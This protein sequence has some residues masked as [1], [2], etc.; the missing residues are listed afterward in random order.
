MS[1]WRYIASRLH[2]DGTENVIHADL[3]LDKVQ[4]TDTLSGPQAIN[5]SIKPEV[6]SLIGSDGEPVFDAWSTAIYAEKDGQIRGGSILDDMTAKG[7]GTLQLNTIGFAGYPKGMPYMGDYQGIQVDPIDV[8]RHIWDHLQ[9]QPHGNLGVT[10]DSTKSGLKIG[11]PPEQVQ[12]TTGAGEDVSFVAGPVKL[13]WYQTHDLLNKINELV[14]ETPFDYREVHSWSG[15]TI[16]HRIQ[17]GYPSLGRRRHDLRFMVGE[18]VAIAPDVTWAGESYASEVLMLGAGQGA[19]TARATATRNDSRIRRV[20]VVDDKAAKDVKSLAASG[21]RE[22]AKRFGR[23]EISE[24]RVFDHPH[25]KLGSYQVGDEIFIQT[26]EGW[27]GDLGM[28]CRIFSNTIT[29]YDDKVAT[30]GVVR[31]DRI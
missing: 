10:L 27:Q 4:I 29:T 24:I 14:R 30:L 16:K 23:P 5:A 8:F 9:S 12:F 2:G 20:A 18:N 11:T 28:W 17:I 22:L 3:P 15:E 31:V 25:A 7:D 26:P 6:A 21:K 19:K 13:A 1:D